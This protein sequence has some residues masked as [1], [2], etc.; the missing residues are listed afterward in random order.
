VPQEPLEIPDPQDHKG[1]RVFRALRGLQALRD[2]LER[3]VLPEPLVQLV[4]ILPCLVLQDQP[5][6]KVNKEYKELQVQQVLLVILV[7]LVPLAML[8]LLVLQALLEQL[9]LQETLDLKDPS[10][11]LEPLEPQV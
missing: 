3:Q 4:Q 9:A 6:H 2:P 5:A 7:L 11:L 10:D 1:N 8:V